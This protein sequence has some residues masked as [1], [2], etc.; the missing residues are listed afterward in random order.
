MKKLIFLTITHLTF[1]AI[2]FAVG[3]FTLPIL[4]APASPSSSAVELQSKQ[5][6][7]K[8]EFKRDLKGSDFLHWG[9]G[10]VFINHK[11]ISFMGEIAP[12]PDYKL[13]LSPSFVDTKEEFLKIKETSLN[14]GEVKTFKNFIVPIPETADISKYNSLVIWC[15]SFGAFI[16]AAKYK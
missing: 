7:F 11:S 12:G 3:I 13:Y 15:E 4:I 10:K 2:G 5:A 6:Q 8:T 16:T 9:D 14:I 1:A